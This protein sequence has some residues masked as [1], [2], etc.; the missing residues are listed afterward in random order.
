MRG[1]EERGL[2]LAGWEPHALIE[3]GAM[4]AAERSGIGL[5]GFL[6]V[7]H[8]IGREEPGP[9]GSDAVEGEGDTCLRSLGC[10]PLGNGFRS[11]F[12]LWVDLVG[13]FLQVAHRSDTG[14]HGQRVAAQ[15]AG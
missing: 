14:G 1:A 9:H 6:V 5:R 7:C 13:V 12:E 8:W 15:R 4:E 3:H 2:K 10:Y 11:G